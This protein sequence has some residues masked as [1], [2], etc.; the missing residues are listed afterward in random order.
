[1]RV[2]RN[3]WLFLVES[4]KWKFRAGMQLRPGI[5]LMLSIFR[6]RSKFDCVAWVG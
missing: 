6:A 5:G 1:M 4:R 3:A 2:V